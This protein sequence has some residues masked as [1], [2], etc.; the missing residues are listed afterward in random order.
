MYSAFAELN[1]PLI[2][3]K[4]N[5]PLVR[6]LSVDL[7]VRYERYSDFG[8]ATKPKG[9]LNYRMNR[10]LALRGSYNEGF[11]APNI[12]QLFSGTIQR[13]NVGSN[14]PYR[15]PVTALISDTSGAIKNLR[16]GNDQLKPEETTSRTY[17]VVVEV[18]FIKGLSFT[19][20]YYKI[21]QTDAIGIIDF[22]DQLTIDRDLLVAETRRQ[23]AAGTPIGSVNLAGKGNPNVTRFPVS[24]DDRDR[25]AAFN[26]TAVAANQRG[27]IGALDFVNAEYVNA[28]SRNIEGFDIA[29]EYRT[30]QFRLGRFTLKTD[31]TYTKKF[32]V[33]NSRGGTF[34]NQRWR[35]GLP[36]W[37]GNASVRWDRDQLSVGA[38][39]RFVGRFQN[40][41]AVNDQAAASGFTADYISSSRFL[42]VDSWWTFNAFASYRF[43]KESAALGGALRDT[44]LRFGLN[45]VLG[46]EPPVA[47]SQYGFNSGLHNARG[48]SWYVEATKRF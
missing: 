16:N 28:A 1:I 3:G 42:I 5:I 40:T 43:K 7:A 45:N 25:F 17:G 38:L 47:D 23:V 11:R 4:Q 32:E 6:S 29:T 20:D 33:Q 18:P 34:S 15:G 13:T 2:G 10:W 24:Q 30:P 26:G 9:G 39:G 27:A 14:D 31:A 22:A 44:T 21:R 36:L 41:S 35:D 12:A 19:V 46:E 48:R 37:R 8:A